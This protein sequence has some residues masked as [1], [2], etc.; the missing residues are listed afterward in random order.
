MG[1]C[2]FD[3]WKVLNKC[4]LL[5]KVIIYSHMYFFKKILWENKLTEI[6]LIVQIDL[7][8]RAEIH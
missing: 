3:I 4:K 1:P 7:R 8:G 6:T 5:L 2:I